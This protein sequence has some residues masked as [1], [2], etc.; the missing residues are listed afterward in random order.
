MAAIPKCSPLLVAL[1]L[2]TTISGLL[3]DACMICFGAKVGCYSANPFKEGFEDLK[4]NFGRFSV[5]GCLVKKP[6][7]LAWECLPWY[8]DKFYKL[9]PFEQVEIFD[10]SRNECRK[11]VPAS[12]SFI[13]V[14]TIGNGYSGNW[15]KYGQHA[16]IKRAGASEIPD[17]TTL[18][19]TT[20]TREPPTLPPD[21]EETLTLAH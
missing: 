1:L 4:H 12:W 3:V 21:S 14:V 15:L 17:N 5:N 18:P 8:A 10:R 16:I 19:M 20:S 2:A 7:E 13:T 11:N 6:F 9:E